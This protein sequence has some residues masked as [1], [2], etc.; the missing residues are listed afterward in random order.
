MSRRRSLGV[1]GILVL[2]T[3]LLLVSS[4]GIWTNRQLLDNQNW[5]ASSAKLLERPEVRSTLATKLV[6]QLYARYDVSGA[7]EQ[8]LPPATKKLAPVIAS[9]LQTASIR[10]TEAFLAT[11]QAQQLWIEVS[12]RAHDQIV[13]ALEG[14]KVRNIETSNGSIVLDVRPILSRLTDRLGVTDKVKANAP[15]NAGLIVLVRSDQLKQAQRVVRAVRIVSVVF[16]LLAL[17]LFVLGVYL[18]RG[19]RMRVLAGVG[20]CLVIVGLILAIARRGTGQWITGSLVKTDANRPAVKVV[21]A[22]ET[23]LLRDLAIILIVYGL[24]V[25]VAAWLGSGARWAVELRRRLAPTFREHVVAVYG[26]AAVLF[27]ALL[28]WGPSAGS[29]RAPGVILLAALIV[30]GIAMWRRQMLAEEATAT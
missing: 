8:Q 30:F 23:E 19:S 20:G 16:A 17:L 1:T 29:R 9:A 25:I 6:D 28:A 21:W 3:L 14:K 24:G 2:A 10:G 5:K 27:L 11:P 22:I 13:R 26:V 12:T 4:L 7:L 18:A 15:A